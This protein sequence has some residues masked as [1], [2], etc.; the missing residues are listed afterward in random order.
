MLAKQEDVGASSRKL[1]HHTS[2]SIDEQSPTFSSFSFDSLS[3]SLIFSFRKPL[4]FSRN[5]LHRSPL[6][7]ALFHKCLS[8]GEP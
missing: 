4:R 8:L 3:R 7:P 5:R 1:D 2:M 6:D